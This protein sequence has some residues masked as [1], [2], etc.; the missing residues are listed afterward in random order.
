MSARFNICRRTN[1]FIAVATLLPAFVLAHGATHPHSHAPD[2]VT[3]TNDSPGLWHQQALHRL[4]VQL[5]EEFDR[6]R[7]HTGYEQTAEKFRLY[8]DENGL[9]RLALIDDMLRQEG[10]TQHYRNNILEQTLTEGQMMVEK[11]GYFREKL[12]LLALN[13]LVSGNFSSTHFRDAGRLLF[14]S[15]GKLAKN[16]R[17]N[18]LA[19]LTTPNIDTD[20]ESLAIDIHV[21]T[22]ASFDGTSNMESLILS[23]VE[24]G[25]DAIAITDHDHFDEVYI[26]QQ[27]VERL[28]R[29]GRIPPDFLVIPGQEISSR[30]GHILALFTRY[31]IPAGLPATQTIAEIHRQGGLAIAPHPSEPHFGL[32]E[33]QVQCL[34]LDG[35]VLTG[36]TPSEFLRAARL[37]QEVRP[38]LAIFMDTDAHMENG[39][40]W[41]GYTLV[42][43][44]DRSPEGIKTAIRNRR[45]QPVYRKVVHALLQGVQSP[46]LQPWFYP[47][48]AYHSREA[49]LESLLA[50]VC[51]ASSVEIE[52]A[53]ERPLAQVIDLYGAPLY[54]RRDALEN[55]RKKRFV[56]R[57]KIDYGALRVTLDTENETRLRLHFKFAF[58]PL[59][60]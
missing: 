18:L 33:K 46:L 52:T 53:I 31:A 27:A 35:M 45:T 2:S 59:R 24:R 8:I 6:F 1:V 9:D 36:S 13:Y 58:N 22:I 25:L 42:H 11:P 28:Q 54:L 10:M 19:R 29:E 4:L 12:K 56:R 39:V 47:L 55:L 26:A 3:V 16:T 20:L 17:L 60:G 23:A 43:T 5:L 49:F 37:A 32:G 57:V 34:P 21:H 48:L 7:L 40:A 30:E 51:R 14:K 15:T 38:R 50:K 44:R 41:S